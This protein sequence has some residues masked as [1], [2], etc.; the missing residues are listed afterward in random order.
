MNLPNYNNST[1]L[2][3]EGYDSKKVIVD[4]L[5]LSY[6]KEVQDGEII[7]MLNL[8][9]DDSPCLTQRPPRKCVSVVS[10]HDVT[11]DTPTNLTT[12]EGKLA[13]V[14]GTKFYYDGVEKGTLTAGKKQMV[15]MINRIIIFP[16][17]KYYDV[18]AGTLKDLESSYTGTSITFTTNY[19]EKQVQILV[20]N[21]ALGMLYTLAVVQ[22]KH[23]IIKMVL[24]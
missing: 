22:Q 12:K 21:S 19:I 18:S 5:G 17:K 13:W 9:S 20:Q 14:D 10:G 4:F 1:N 24:T 16:D 2:S 3:K 15:T 6:N 7:D 23:K 11:F 8:S